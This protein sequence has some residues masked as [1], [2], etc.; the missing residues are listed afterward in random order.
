MNANFG[1]WLRRARR[2]AGLSQKQLCH[3]LIPAGLRLMQSQITKTERGERPVKLNEAVAMAQMFG[4]TL[5]VALGLQPGPSGIAAEEAERR[6]VLLKQA[7]RRTALLNQLR[8]QIDAELG[9]DAG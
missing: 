1:D 7:A 8:D 3:A 6:A 4:T 5:D 2:D 9:G